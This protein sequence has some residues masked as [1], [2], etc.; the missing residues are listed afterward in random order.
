[1]Q[2][3]ACE[4]RDHS[5]IHVFVDISMHHRPSDSIHLHTRLAQP[6]ASRV[7]GS[8]DLP[9]LPSTDVE[10][11]CATARLHRTTATSTTVTYTIH[12]SQLYFAVYLWACL[13]EPQR[14]R[15]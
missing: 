14:H 15:R 1:M 8:G 12:F 10:V 6:Y 3:E 11:R 5:L 7:W 2:S 9:R 4:H 13:T